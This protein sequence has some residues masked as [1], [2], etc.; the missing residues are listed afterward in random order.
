MFDC[1]IPIGQTCN[2][3]FLMQHKKLKKETSLF[4]WFISP[5]LRD[6]TH[7]LIKIGNNEDMDS[8][9]F[10]PPYIYRR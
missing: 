2:I 8:V 6:I 4:E 7:V 3:T 5:T 10:R 1:I 9:Q